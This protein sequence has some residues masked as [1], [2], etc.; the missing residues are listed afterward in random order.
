MSDLQVDTAVLHQAGAG[1]RAVYR[2]FR[3]AGEHARPGAEVIAHDGLRDRLEEFADGWDDRRTRMAEGIEA[4]G[5]I[6][7]QAAE[8]YEEIEQ[9]LVAALEGR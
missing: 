2:E 3:D 9:H 1:L 6:A 7:T 4:L 8:A 5:E